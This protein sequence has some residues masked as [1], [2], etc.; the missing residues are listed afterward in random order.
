MHGWDFVFYLTSKK[1]T[2]PCTKGCLLH[3]KNRHAQLYISFKQILY[4]LTRRRQGEAV[5]Q[6]VR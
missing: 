6:G 4:I 1:K 5:E 3:V 2:K